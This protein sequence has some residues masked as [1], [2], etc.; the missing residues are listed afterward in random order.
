MASNG[1]LSKKLQLD[2]ATVNKHPVNIDIFFI[3]INLL[4]R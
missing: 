2:N 4:E 3:L 1:S